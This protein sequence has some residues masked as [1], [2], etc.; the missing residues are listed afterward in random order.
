M[1]DELAQMELRYERL[2]LL[3]QVSNVIHSTLDSQEA[4]QLIVSEAV[5]LMN[6]A[7][8]SVVLVNPTTGIMEISASQNLPSMA[9]R[10]KLRVGEGITGWVA[11]TGRPAC[12]GDV[13]QDPRYVSVRRGVK[14]ELAV[15]LEVEGEI[16]GV[17]NVDSDRANAFTTEHQTLLQELAVQAA[18][19]IH[20]TWLYEQLRLKVHL[21]ETLASV[22]RTINST[23]NLDEALR[24]I[25]SEACGLMRARM[26]SLMML[27]ESREWLDLR[28]SYGAGEVYVK[29]PRLTVAE[30]LLGVVVRRRKP[31][32]VA[33]VQVSSRYQ[34]V[35]VARREGL[36]SL[37][38]VPLLFAGQAIG[39]LSVY[40]S[41]PYH[42]SNE[43]VSILSALAELSAIAIEKARLYERIVDV[44][45]QLRQNEKLSALGLLAAEVAHEIRNPLT[46][47]KLLYHSL[48]LKFPES[49]PR[50]KDTRIIEAK[51]EHLNKIV[52][53]ILDFARTTEPKLAP[54]NLNELVD[55]LGL[56]VRHKLAN[57]NVRLVRDLQSDLPLIQGDAPQLEQVFLNLILNAAEA[58]P[59][60]G[61]LT[62]RSRGVTP[63]AMSQNAPHVTVEF[64][65]T[66]VGMSEEVQRGAFTAMLATTKAKGTGL[67]LAIV[68][69]IIET[70]RGTLGIKSRPGKGT[71]IRID[72]PLK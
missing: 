67:G 72:L 36:V 69:R 35:E 27:D 30:S 7:S 46:V 63:P 3:Y 58:M 54:V 61:T 10:L 1:S 38:S 18:K 29:K 64:K 14:S 37:L 9:K 62:I 45:E 6:A 32:Q 47:M 16:R 17:L 21:F 13:T 53:Q 60:G 34:N 55:E 25:T 43:E 28:A 24:A 23:L 59:E 51:I 26:C 71:T 39:T 65:D 49:D 41:R 11:R 12:V 42:F 68:G 8:G 52:E 19:V 57:Q 33:N 31:L 44:E 4:L 22:S 40:T 50:S 20:K 70:H 2:L 5:R 48:D 15:P 56:L 66:G